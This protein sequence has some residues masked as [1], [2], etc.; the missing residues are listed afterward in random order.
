MQYSLQPGE[1]NGPAY[2]SAIVSE[3]SCVTAAGPLSAVPMSTAIAVS[4]D[5]GAEALP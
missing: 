4:P 2:T 3:A 5:V 1:Q